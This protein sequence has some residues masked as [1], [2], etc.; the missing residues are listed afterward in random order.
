[1]HTRRF[2]RF[3]TAWKPLFG[4]AL[5]S[6]TVSACVIP[7]APQFDDPET[8]SPPFISDS[9]PGEGV[10]ITP[11]QAAT[12]SIITVTLGDLN[13]SDLLFVRWLVDYPNPGA[14]SSDSR[15][16]MKLEPAPTGKIERGEI[17]FRPTCPATPG[18]SLRRLVLSVADR[19]FLEPE[20]DSVAQDAPLDSVP[21]GA[22]RFRAVWLLNCPSL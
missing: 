4:V 22:N 21:T 9:S 10:I 12:P 2:V 1:M 16:L 15:V 5:A 19:K 8:N 14:A 13:V 11:G 17:K 18:L 3:L 7:I 20:T 6:I